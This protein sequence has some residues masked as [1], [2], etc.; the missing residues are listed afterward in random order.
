MQVR[1]YGEYNAMRLETPEFWV[2]M[3]DLPDASSRVSLMKKGI[4]CEKAE[5]V[6]VC[7]LAIAILSCRFF[8][9][10]YEAPVVGARE[11]L[12]MPSK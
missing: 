11:L 8:T 2:P 9:I 7:S 4:S 6:T 3:T 12:K 1:R 5:R 10:P